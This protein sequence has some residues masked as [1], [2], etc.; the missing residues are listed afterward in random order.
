MQFP[1][2]SVSFWT[3][4]LP[5]T[6]LLLASL[7]LFIVPAEANF[8][9]P[10]AMMKMATDAAKG[11]MEGGKK[12]KSDGPKQIMIFTGGDLYGS[13]LN[14]GDDEEKGK[15]TKANPQPRASQLGGFGGWTGAR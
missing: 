9:D 1:F 3:L 4:M 2:V 10:A 6:G 15:K 7:L 8:A 14:F 12:S 11:G 13:G 5:I